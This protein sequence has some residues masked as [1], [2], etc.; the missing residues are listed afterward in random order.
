MTQQ[1]WNSRYQQN[2]LAYG[3]SPNE[4]LVRS[5][6]YLQPGS[7]ILAA[8]DGEGR[9]GIWLAARQ[10]Q[11]WAIDYSLT[12][13]K[14]AKNLAESQGHL[15]RFICADLSEWKWPPDFFQA[16]VIIFVHFPPGIREQVHLSMMSSLQDKGIIILQCF[17]QEQLK[18]DSGG[19]KAAEML[20]TLEMLKNDF[21]GMNFIAAE[22]SETDLQEG[23]F[24]A[25]RAAVVNAVIQKS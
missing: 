9:N 11:V 5:A 12:G 22:E 3:D 21:R 25:G 20:Y 14:K 18:Y 19:P 1:F 6:K 16:I 10:R 13:L 24:H 17:H 23:I 4:F 15:V 7:R 8:G 2:V